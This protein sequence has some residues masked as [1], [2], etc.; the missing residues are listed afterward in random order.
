MAL[1]IDLVS[2][3][4]AWTPVATREP[5]TALLAVGVS[6]RRPPKNGVVSG[7]PRPRRTENGID[8]LPVTELL[9]RSW[10]DEIVDEAVTSS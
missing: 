8:I 10:A 9:H 7:D 3:H 2:S 1:A 6:P 5:D 4:G